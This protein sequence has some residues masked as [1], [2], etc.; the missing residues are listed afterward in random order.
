MMLLQQM[1]RR[2]KG[3]NKKQSD[4]ISAS[5]SQRST[6]AADIQEMKAKSPI[7]P[8]E[9]KR[10]SDDVGTSSAAVSQGNISMKMLT[11]S[12]AALASSAK[13]RNSK[14]RIKR[15]E[16][17][18]AKLSESLRRINMLI[19]GSSFLIVFT[20][21]VSFF[22]FAITIQAGNEKYSTNVHTESDRYAFSTDAIGWLALIGNAYCIYYTFKRSSDTTA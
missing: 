18:L 22:V 8:I 3:P 15:E 10:E 17:L 4:D 14:S 21:A 6:R 5:V 16:K 9:T 11:P 7:A 19:L 1:E 2:A 12:N 20:L 13:M